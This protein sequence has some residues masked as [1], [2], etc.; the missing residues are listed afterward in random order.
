MKEFDLMKSE[1]K[2]AERFAANKSNEPCFLAAW[3]Y[4]GVDDLGWA[5]VLCEM[6]NTNNGEYVNTV[7]LCVCMSDRRFRVGRLLHLFSAGRFPGSQPG[8]GFRGFAAVCSTRD[9]F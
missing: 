2:K 4:S 6:G 8:D 9:V 3:S 5:D 7:H 1:I